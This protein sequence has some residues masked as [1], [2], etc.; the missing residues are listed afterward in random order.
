MSVSAP[1]AFP[2]STPSR[3]RRSTASS[4]WSSVLL[5]SGL[6]RRRRV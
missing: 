4:G 5:L 3:C 1:A 6:A 2:A